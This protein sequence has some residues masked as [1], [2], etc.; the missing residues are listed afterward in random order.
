MLISFN[1]LMSMMFLL[2]M[3]LYAMMDIFLMMDFVITEEDILEKT[4]KNY[5]E[6]SIFKI[7][8]KNK[9]FNK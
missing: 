6:N 8:L 3:I 9:T 4:Q 2:T 5:N 7:K 1:Q